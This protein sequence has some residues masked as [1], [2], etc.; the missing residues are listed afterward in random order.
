[1]SFDLP[2]QILTCQRNFGFIFKQMELL[3]VQSVKAV[4]NYI[5]EIVVA[6]WNHQL[7]LYQFMLIIKLCNTW[8]TLNGI[9]EG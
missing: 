6:T 7:W 4:N 9:V 1:M 2:Q 5:E 3:F 8:L